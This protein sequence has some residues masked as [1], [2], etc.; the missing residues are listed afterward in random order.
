MCYEALRFIRRFYDLFSLDYAIRVLSV[1]VVDGRFWRC[2]EVLSPAGLGSLVLGV[3]AF[4][5]CFRSLP[6]GDGLLTQRL[7]CCSL[8]A[9]PRRI[10]QI[11][12]EL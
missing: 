11:S 5:F 8:A 12:S 6:Q 3:A 1:G 9:I 4:F 2:L 10:H 7:P